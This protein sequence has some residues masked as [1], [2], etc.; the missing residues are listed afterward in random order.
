MGT[1]GGPSI[2]EGELG[3]TLGRFGDSFITAI[4]KQI[5]AGVAGAG[6]YFASAGQSGKAQVEFLQRKMLNNFQQLILVQHSYDQRYRRYPH[7]YHREQL[8]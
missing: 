2:F 6:G 1:P 3:K 5:V 7:F 8:Y 4:Q